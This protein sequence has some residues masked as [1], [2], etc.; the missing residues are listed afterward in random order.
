MSGAEFVRAGLG[1]AAALIA[2]AALVQASGSA[3]AHAGPVK[4]VEKVAEAKNPSVT[5]PSATRE[6]AVIQTRYGNIEIE[7]FGKDAPEHVA[8]FEKLA[9]E[10]YFDVTAFH[11][12]IPGFVIQGG[13]PNSKDKDPTND[14]QGGPGYTLKAEIKQPHKRGCVA[15]ARLPDQVNPEKRSSGSQFYICLKDLPNLDRDGYTVFGRVI[16]GMDVVDRIAAVK[17]DGRDRP[18]DPVVMTKV[19]IEVR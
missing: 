2:G 10:G 12:V 1:A 14:G 6:V 11:R 13:D 7:F 19:T 16:K 18:L 5:V 17:R 3:R 8:N 4:E 15:A 9:R